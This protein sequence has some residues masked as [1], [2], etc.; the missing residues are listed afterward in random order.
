MSDFLHLPLVRDTGLLLLALVLGGA[1]G[2]ER[3]QTEHPAGLRTH[4]LV[5]VGAALIA[6]IDHGLP[7]AGGRIVAQVVTGIGFL[8][9]G[10]ILRESSGAMVRGLTTAASIWTVAGIGIAVGS[11]GIFPALAAIGTVIVFITLRV[12]DKLE[13][14]LNRG[15][16]LQELTFLIATA[17]EPLK[18]MNDALN[19]LHQLGIQTG[20]FHFESV[21]GG[22]VVHVTLRLPNPTVRDAVKPTLEANPNVV[23]VEWGP[24]N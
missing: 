10:T 16:R 11:G 22:E 7:R 1:I 2:M 15:R 18:R 21:Q 24:G 8:G 17:D 9:A 14:H 13:N 6:I 19:S 20:R 12:L 23:H 4:I 5:C 3:E